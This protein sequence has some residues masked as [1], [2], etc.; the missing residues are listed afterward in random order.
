ME[1]V[2]DSLFTT[3]TNPPQ[4]ITATSQIPNIQKTLFKNN[5]AM[6]ELYAGMESDGGSVYNFIT[7]FINVLLAISKDDEKKRVD[8][9][10]MSIIKS[11]LLMYVDQ[12]IPSKTDKEKNAQFIATM[13]GFVNRFA[14][15]A[16][17]GN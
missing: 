6:G 14:E 16:N 7:K 12:V 9:R 15:N 17:V 13:V 3:Q 10:L 1:N 5:Y 2:I 11:S 4:Q 8:D